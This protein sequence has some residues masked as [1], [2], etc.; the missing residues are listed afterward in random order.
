MGAVGDGDGDCGAGCEGE[1]GD[2]IVLDACV[3]VG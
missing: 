1:G 3:V 2:G